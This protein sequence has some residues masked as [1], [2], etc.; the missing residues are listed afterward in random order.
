MSMT[1]GPGAD[2]LDLIA[3]LLSDFD[4]DTPRDEFYGRLCEALCQMTSMERAVLFLYDD[5]RHRVRAVGSHGFDIAP[6]ESRNIT[7]EDAPIAQRAF[8]EDRVVE[9]SEDI[10]SQLPPGYA[11]LFGITTLTCTPL[12]AGGRRLG[13]ILADRGGGRFSLSGPE[14]YAMLMLGKTAA[15]AASTRIATR[16]HEKA[17]RLSERIDLAREVHERVV[18]RLFGVSL[19]IGSGQ[20]LSDAERERCAVEI[21]GA[22]AD[23]R[24]ALQRP[25]AVSAPDTQTTLREELD[26]L[27]AHYPDLKVTVDWQPDFAVSPALEPVAQS[28]LAEALRNAR[29][30]AVATAVGV[31]V[32]SED[33]ALVLEVVNDGV[34]DRANGQDAGIGL[35][36]AAFQALQAGGVLEFGPAPEL[37]WRVRLVVPEQSR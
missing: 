13:V 26:R 10:E 12:L 2:A 35:R 3:D 9:V 21:Q 24:I 27:V 32:G 5:A 31:S 11:E 25:L 28:V 6:L 18:Q 7:L 37:R 4:G 22:L 15:L 1:W 29:K 33:G 8:A 36:L 16:Q 14:R 20:E 30:H 34:R 19:A 17:R 23:L